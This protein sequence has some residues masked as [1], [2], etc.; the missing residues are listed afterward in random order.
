MDFFLTERGGTPPPSR[1]A[2]SKKPNGK[3]LA[4]RGGTPPPSQTISV[5]GV[6]ETFPYYDNDDD[7]VFM[8]MMMMMNMMVMTIVKSN[9]RLEIVEQNV[10]V[11]PENLFI[12]DNY[13]GKMIISVLM[14]IM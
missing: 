8:V 6:F 7:D 9:C 10:H 3:K 13:H 14:A 2:G 1:T 12:G 5:T 11:R 4:E